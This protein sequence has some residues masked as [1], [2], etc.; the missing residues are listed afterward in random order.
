MNFESLQN[1]EFPDAMFNITI[2]TIQVQ[3]IN[4]EWRSLWIQ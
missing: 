1:D 3:T 2:Q 4:E